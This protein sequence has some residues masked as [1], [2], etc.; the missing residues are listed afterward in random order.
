MLWFLKMLSPGPS[1]RILDVGG[2][3]SFWADSD[4]PPGAIT[5]LNVR[6][7][8]G[9]RRHPYVI[10]DACDL[11]FPDQAF[12][13]VFSNSA[14][15]HVGTWQRQVAFA[16]EVRRV[17]RAFWVQTPAREFVV[18]PHLM[19]PF[20]HWLPRRA[21]R[22][23]IRNAS[24]WGWVTRPSEA[25]VDAFL[26]EVRLLSHDEVMRL[27]P[28]GQLLRERTAGLTKSYVAIRS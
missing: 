21:Q 5:I 26:E 7:P 11:P 23:L 10:G 8:S 6:P 3:E 1:A 9:P 22:R 18:E 24:L 13:I 12:D 4:I 19:T 25:Q 17:G 27:F 2:D 15:E 14:I 20:I 28:D 16:S